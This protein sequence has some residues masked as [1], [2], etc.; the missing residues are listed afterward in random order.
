MEDL[1]SNE[2][3]T[4]ILSDLNIGCCTVFVSFQENNILKLGDFA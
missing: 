2:T 1:E 3:H 4:S